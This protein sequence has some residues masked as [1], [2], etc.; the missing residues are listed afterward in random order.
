[1]RSA[2]VWAVLFVIATG[3]ASAQQPH[4]AMMGAGSATCAD[5]AEEYRRDPDTANH[6]YFSWAQGCRSGLNF[7]LSP[8]RPM[9]DL[10]ALT[11][12]EQLDH[13]RRFC[14]Q[15]PLSLFAAAAQ[16]LFKALPT[17]PP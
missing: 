2:S 3:E 9:H 14:D 12:A 10:N 13:L 11:I 6:L 7:E 1:M 4:A 16:N 17:L 8:K 5:Y 15:K